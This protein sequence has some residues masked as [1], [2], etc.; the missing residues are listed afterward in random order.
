[1]DGRKGLLTQVWVVGLRWRNAIQQIAPS[2][3]GSARW[4]LTNRE[5]NAV[6]FDS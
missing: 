6:T 5:T 3:A 1:M 4:F 2:D